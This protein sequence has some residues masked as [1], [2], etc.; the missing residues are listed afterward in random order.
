MSVGGYG[1]AYA[2]GGPQNAEWHWR[3]PVEPGTWRLSVLSDTNVDRGQVQFGI[4]YDNGNN[5]TNIGAIVDLYSAAQVFNV[6]TVRTIAVTNRG[7]ALL[8]AYV[9]SKNASSS[10]YFWFLGM[11]HWSRT[12]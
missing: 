8:R 12:A 5:W 11:M 6:R 2:T 7:T 9:P 4:S 3:I 10:G 1:A